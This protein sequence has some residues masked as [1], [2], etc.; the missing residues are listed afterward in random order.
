MARSR[1]WAGRPVKFKSAADTLIAGPASPSSARSRAAPGRCAWPAAAGYDPAALLGGCAGY[2]F[3]RG[4]GQLFRLRNL[5][6]RRRR[7][8][9]AGRDQRP[10]GQSGAQGRSGRSAPGAGATLDNA[11]KVE[12]SAT[13]FAHARDPDQRRQAQDRRRKRHRRGCGHRKRQGRDQRRL[14]SIAAAGFSQDV[15]FHGGHRRAD[16][17][18]SRRTTPARSPAF[19]HQRRREPGS[20]GH[21]LRRFGRGD[22]R[23]DGERRYA[24]RQRRDPHRRHRPRRATISARPSPPAATATAGRRWSI[25][26][27]A[28]SPRF[29]RSHGRA[30]RAKPRRAARHFHARRGPRVLVQ[31][32]WAVH[33]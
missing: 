33:A 28:R 8:L 1:A 5:R 4:H 29:C 12:I 9:D 20:A 31:P 14:L 10:G 26:A 25:R 19:P 23:R 27:P 15:D 21:R 16:P 2:A 13:G 6:G 18:S 11:G 3:G 17:C 32:L 30:G 22:V 7:R 24:H